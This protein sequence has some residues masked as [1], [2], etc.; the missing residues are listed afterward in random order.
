MFSPQRRMYDSILVGETEYEVVVPKE[1]DIQNQHL[2]FLPSLCNF[3]DVLNSHFRSESA[4]VD[5]EYGARQN[6]AI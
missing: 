2:H 5:L 1:S 6:G 4:S 3:V